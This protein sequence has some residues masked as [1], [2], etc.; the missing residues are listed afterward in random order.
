MSTNTMPDGLWIGIGM[1]PLLLGRT[2]LRFCSVEGTLYID[3]IDAKKKI[4]LGR[5]SIGYG[6]SRQRNS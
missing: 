3:L 4:D 6:K 1:E 2:H 5:R